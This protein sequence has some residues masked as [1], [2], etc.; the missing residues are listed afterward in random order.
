VKFGQTFDLDH[1]SSR[2]RCGRELI[3]AKNN[4]HGPASKWLK[5]PDASA[6]PLRPSPLP[7]PRKRHGE[8]G[9]CRQ[10]FSKSKSG[11]V[12][13]A[14]SA[15]SGLEESHPGTPPVNGT[16]ERENR[17]QSISERALKPVSENSFELTCRIQ[18]AA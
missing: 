12:Q 6:S 10:A 17:W 7:S 2:G 8:K 11:M 3:W 18:K 16:G 5:K 14:Q 13:R 9:N 15:N 4:Q 1:C